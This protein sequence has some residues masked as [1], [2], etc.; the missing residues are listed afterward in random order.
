MVLPAG[1][2]K[3]TGLK[4]AVKELGLSLHNVVGVGDAE[5]D[6]AF[7]SVCECSV[8]VG[9]A[10]PSIK[11]RAD[12][13]TPGERGHGVT[14]L[15]NQLLADDLRRFDSHLTHHRIVI[16]STDGN[17]VKYLPYGINALL[18]GKSVAERPRWQ[19][20]TRA[21]CGAELQVCILDPEGDYADLEGA[22][23]LGSRQAVP[24][25]DEILQILDNPETHTVVNLLG[26][27]WDERRLSS[28]TSS[29]FRNA[30][31]G[32]PLAGC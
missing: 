21:P 6:H 1:I 15:V 7:M 24:Q 22:V 32:R 25:I 16:G 30:R 2:N 3:A 28:K 18:A 29:H 31:Y 26:L 10:L 12:I 27:P 8:A 13:V 14:E 11:E 9:N 4:A 19:P 5:N 17:E 20:F 23:V